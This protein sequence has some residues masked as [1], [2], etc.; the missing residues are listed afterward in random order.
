LIVPERLRAAHWAGFDGT[1]AR[2][3]T[4]QARRPTV[5][6]SLTRA[7]ATIYGEMSFA[8]VIGSDGKFLGAVA[9]PRDVT[10]LQ[11][12][13]RPTASFK[14]PRQEHQAT[15]STSCACS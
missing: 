4:Q 14:Q 5:T 7:G 1:M 13:E 9:M 12:D 6:R 10:Q 11:S 2:G 15:F 3:G 8:V